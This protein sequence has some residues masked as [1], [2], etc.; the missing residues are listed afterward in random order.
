MREYLKHNEGNPN[1]RKSKKPVRPRIDN[2]GY[3]RCD[4]RCQASRA[5][6]QL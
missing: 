5:E 4:R 6:S 1:K 2:N 3:D